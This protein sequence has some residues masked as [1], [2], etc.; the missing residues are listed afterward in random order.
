M[1]HLLHLWIWLVSIAVTPP[2]PARTVAQPRP[3]LGVTSLDST[4]AAA[5][6]ALARGRPW[7]ATRLLTPWLRDS[8]HRTPATVFLAAS[9][10]SEWRGWSEVLELLGR[11]SWLDSLHGGRGR[12]LL[13]RAALERGQDSVAL[14]H[15]G[16]AVRG[17]AES[18]ERLLLL[19]SALDRVG[20]R[21][22]AAEL[23]A[24]AAVRLPTVSDWLL[25]RA[26]AGT[27]DS[28]ARARLYDGIAGS[29]ART[30]IPYADAAAHERTG[31]LAG[32]ARRYAAVGDRLTSLR[33]RLAMSSDSVPRS[34]VP[35]SYTHLTLP[36]N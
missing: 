30:R 29:L 10:A 32:A 11:E 24:R 33:L 35:V 22:S 1:T 34:E 2:A 4:L 18:G 36:T 16:M 26:A 20:A 12:V 6:L 14:Y 19:A 27:D 8:S 25:L 3:N 28:S 21:D 5:R 31:D 15:A 7:Q 17:D 23:Y 9:A 13:A